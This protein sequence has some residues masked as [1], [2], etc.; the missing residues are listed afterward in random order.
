MTAKDCYP[1]PFA[2]GMMTCALL[3]ATTQGPCTSDTIERQDISE[4]F[5]GLPVRLA[6]KFVHADTCEP[7]EGAVVQ[8]WHTQRTGVYSGVTPKPMLCHGGDTEAEE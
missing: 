3:G 5:S 1:D 6:L 2:A 8:I 7:V 4:G